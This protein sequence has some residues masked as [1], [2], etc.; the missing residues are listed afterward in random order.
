M[1]ENLEA[2]G[3]QGSFLQP[4]DPDI[5]RPWGDDGSRTEAV[6]SV[7]PECERLDSAPGVQGPGRQGIVSVATP[8]GMPKPRNPRHFDGIEGGRKR[9]SDTFTHKNSGSCT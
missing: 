9:V 1:Y 6:G 3:A 7:S 4:Q 2:I 5:R 8:L